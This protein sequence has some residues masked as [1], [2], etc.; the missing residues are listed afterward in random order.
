[1]CCHATL[2]REWST[3]HDTLL[4]QTSVARI[5]ETR[6]VNSII[7]VDIK[8]WVLL[9]EPQVNLEINLAPLQRVKVWQLSNMLARHVRSSF[10][11]ATLP[12]TVDCQCWWKMR[13]CAKYKCTH[14]TTKKCSPYMACLPVSCLHMYFTHSL[15]SRKVRDSCIWTEQW[16]NNLIVSDPCSYG[17]KTRNIILYS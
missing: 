16:N 11:L 6:R 15:I 10:V 5:W 7:I 17:V 1:M 8:L 12:S 9:W 2:R 3:S 4:P 13:E 14:E